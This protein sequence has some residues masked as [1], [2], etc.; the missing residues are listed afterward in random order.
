MPV[1]LDAGS[2]ALAGRILDYFDS[3][4]QAADGRRGIARWWLKGETD[5]EALQKV[6]DLL[7]AQG[8]VQCRQVTGGEAIYSRAVPDNDEFG[9]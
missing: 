9:E 8:Q 2:A 1:E 5:S 6:L 4:P 7:V 3:Y